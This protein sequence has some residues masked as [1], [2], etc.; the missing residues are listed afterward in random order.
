MSQTD[1]NVANAT[2]AVVR[3]DVNAPLDALVTLSSGGTAPTT[4]F[5][6]MWWAD[7][8]TGLLKQRNAAN[9]AWVTIYTLANGP[10]DVLAANNL[11]DVASAAT[12]INNLV[13]PGV[14]GN[15]LT[16]D[17]TNWA[18]AVASGGGAYSVLTSGT[19]TNLNNIDF[20]TGIVSGTIIELEGVQVL[21]NNMAIGLYVSADGGTTWIVTSISY[22]NQTMGN[23]IAWAG[24]GA[25]GSDYF[26]LM[27]DA[28]GSATT[29][30][31]SITI[32]LG[33]LSVGYPPVMWSS[34]YYDALTALAPLRVIGC[35]TIST[36]YNAIRIAGISTNLNL[37][38]RVL[39]PV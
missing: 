7:T 34:V 13:T 3:A 9:T 25:S 19:I 20:T 35:G 10:G 32:K 26:K 14:V 38:Y 15:V 39:V 36:S 28:L 1:M 33:N 22:M 4:T 23:G 37:N 27:E 21:T 6:G 12:S 31:A 30:S 18:S 11:S 17:G 8:S 24:A 2:G 16:S 5:A 29:V